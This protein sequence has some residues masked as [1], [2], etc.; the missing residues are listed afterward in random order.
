MRILRLFIILRTISKYRLLRFLPDSSRLPWVTRAFLRLLSPLGSTHDNNP[1]SLRL[2]FEELGPVFIK[3]GQLLSTR[4]DLFD[5]EISD[6]LQKL[7]D[8]VPPF[9]TRIARR[10]VEESTGS[11]I[12]KQFQTFE[13][14]PLA[15]ASVAQVHA[16]RLLSGE[17]VVIKIIRPDIESIIRKDIAW[18]FL[19]AHLMEKYSREARRLHPVTIVKDYKE[20]I[21]SELDLN[22]EAANASRLGENW[23]GTGK[24]YVPKVFWKFS[25]SRTMVMERV[26]GPMV[27]DLVRLNAAGTDLKKLAHLGVEIFFTQVFEQNFFH[28]DMHP[29]NVFIDITNPGNPSYIALDCAIIGSLTEQDKDYLARNILAFFRRDYASVARLHLDSGWVPPETDLREFESVIRSVCEPMFQK[30]IKDISFGQVLVNLFQTARRFNME[31]QPQ[32]VLL[33]KT[34]INIE[35]LGRQLYPEL[36]LWETAAPFMEEWIKKRH[37]PSR[38]LQ[39]IRDNLPLWLER[40]PELPELTYQ[41]LIEIRQL[42]ASARRQSTLLAEMHSTLENQQNRARSQRVG[43]LIL[44]TAFSGLLLSQLPDFY[45]NGLMWG[46]SV[47]G[48]LGAYWL[49]FRP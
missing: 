48:G 25:S 49:M 1:A 9:P 40:L 15:S 26:Y 6:E 22:L 30:P 46:S 27:S 18:M 14:T 41:A 37:A 42:G 44:L 36:D 28:A 24:L 43:G 3:F 35:G 19:L 32:L 39:D 33:Q 38:I 31:V 45:S 34:L 23:N 5:A 17:D 11:S 7:Q 16:A 21:L 20:T 47:L 29:G 10:I 4:R 12:E 2:A 8:S 13:D